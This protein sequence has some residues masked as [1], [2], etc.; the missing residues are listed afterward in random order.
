M[1]EDSVL[2]GVRTALLPI[3]TSMEKSA[4]LRGLVGGFCSR[5]H[6]GACEPVRVLYVS[7]DR[8]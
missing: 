1:K 5:S 7:P 3:Q 2:Y 4:E 8:S 6:A